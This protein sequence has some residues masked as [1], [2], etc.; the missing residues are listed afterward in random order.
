MCMMMCTFQCIML[1]SV[2]LPRTQSICQQISQQSSCSFV[3]FYF[4]KEN[5]PLLGGWSERNP[6]SSEIKKATE[7]AVKMFNNHSKGKKMFKLVSITSAKAQVRFI[8]Q[9]ESNSHATNCQRHHHA[10]TK[11]NSFLFVCS[12]YQVTNVINF[13]I[14]AVLGKTKCLKSENHDLESCSLDKKVNLCEHLYVFMN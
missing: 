7:Y 8:F 2:I 9:K 3:N 13:K 5:V 11:S 12:F 10:M 6:E 4:L 1:W 14:N